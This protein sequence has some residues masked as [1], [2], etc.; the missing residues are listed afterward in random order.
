MAVVFDFYNGAFHFLWLRSLGSAVVVSGFYGCGLPDLWR[1]FPNSAAA[2]SMICG[3]ILAVLLIG[4]PDL[5]WVS[6][7]SIRIVFRI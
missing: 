5:L 2:V 1:C 3:G 4:F 7:G 6:S